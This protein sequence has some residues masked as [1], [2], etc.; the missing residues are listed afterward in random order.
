MATLLEQEPQTVGNFDLLGGGERAGVDQTDLAVRPVGAD[1]HFPLLDFFQD[2]GLH[3]FR[4]IRVVTDDQQIEG[5]SKDVLPCELKAM[6]LVND[7][8]RYHRT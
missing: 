1:Q 8:R 6:R 7:V 3:S 5:G 4:L 2:A